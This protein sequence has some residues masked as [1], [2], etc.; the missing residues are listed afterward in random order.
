MSLIAVKYLE[1][2]KI[3]LQKSI[4]KCNKYMLDSGQILN[5]MERN[6]KIIEEMIKNEQKTSYIEDIKNIP[7]NEKI[8]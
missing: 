4:D 3:T 1:E 5:E 6:I 7:E 8:F 2:C